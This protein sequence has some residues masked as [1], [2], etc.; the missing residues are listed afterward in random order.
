MQ[1]IGIVPGSV[2]SDVVVQVGSCNDSEPTVERLRVVGHD[3][4]MGDAIDLDENIVWEVASDDAIAV[5]RITVGV[6]PDGMK[7]IV[8]FRDKDM[9][10]FPEYAVELNGHPF[11]AAFTEDSLEHGAAS[12]D[13]AGGELSYEE[14]LDSFRDC[15]C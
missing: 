10:G 4:S 3:P 15:N 7:E 12:V 11:V 13:G 1:P 5:D 9:T 8:P 6:L 2:L 14:W